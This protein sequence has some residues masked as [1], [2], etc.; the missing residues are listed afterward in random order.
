M[1]TVGYLLVWGILFA[2]MMR[3]GCGAHIMGGHHHSHSHT[4]K[5]DESDGE[6]HAK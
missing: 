4:S 2:F 3:F 1:E 6:P 5:Q